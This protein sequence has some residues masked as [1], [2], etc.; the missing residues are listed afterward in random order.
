MT[1]IVSLI[2][3]PLI[4]LNP[5]WSENDPDQKGIDVLY[6]LT[7]FFALGIW[8]VVRRYQKAQYS[9]VPFHVDAPEVHLSIIFF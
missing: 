7:V 1:S 2:L 4:A 5:W 3:N 6:L 9:A 8:L